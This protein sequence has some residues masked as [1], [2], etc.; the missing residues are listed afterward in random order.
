M[1]VSSFKALEDAFNFGLRYVSVS[2]EL[3]G[4][5]S[6]EAAGAISHFGENHYQRSEAEGQRAEL[7]GRGRE[8]LIVLGFFFC[9]STGLS[10]EGRINCLSLS[11]PLLACGPGNVSREL[12][13]YADA[14]KHHT[15]AL[16]MLKS[17]SPR[18]L[19]VGNYTM[20]VAV[21]LMKAD[22]LEEALFMSSLAVPILEAGWGKDSEFTLSGLAN[23]GSI[24][25][26]LG[27]TREADEIMMRVLEAEERTLGATH[28]N[29]CISRSN[30]AS[31]LLGQER[32]AEAV[33]ILEP[34]LQLMETRHLSSDSQI[35]VSVRLQLAECFRFIGQHGRALPLY[36]QVVEGKLYRLG[37]N[38]FEVAAVLCNMSHCLV[39]AGRLEDAVAAMVRAVDISSVVRQNVKSL[40]I[41]RP[42]FFF[43]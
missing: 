32:H 34:L 27:R 5:I 41:L 28:P 1:A 17:I 8:G 24:L 15:R 11:L 21:D 36:D 12:G 23:R 37:P 16:D 43:F 42:F 18:N 26:L 31:S 22:R 13:N 4:P 19:N 33:A 35:L 30:L 25:R 39:G 29:T 40:F 2:E 9:L 7:E 20:A 3:Y 10:S 14:L 6:E 38:S